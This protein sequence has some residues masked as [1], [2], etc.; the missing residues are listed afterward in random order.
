MP[1]SDRSRA[2]RARVTALAAIRSAVGASR[3]STALTSLQSRGLEI[4]DLELDVQ[5]FNVQLPRLRII[6]LDEFDPTR[7][8]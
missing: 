7:Y 5:A 4:H 8:L 2:I 1:G 3:A 6:S